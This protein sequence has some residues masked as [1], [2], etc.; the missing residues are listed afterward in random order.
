MDKTIESIDTTRTVVIARLRLGTVWKT[1]WS[2][3]AS[4]LYDICEAYA[5]TAQGKRAA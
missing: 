4:A 1:V 5:T 3:S 2:V